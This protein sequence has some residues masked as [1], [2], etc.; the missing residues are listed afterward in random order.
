MN[1]AQRLDFWKTLCSLDGKNPENDCKLLSEKITFPRYLYRYRAVNDKNLE[2]LLH[3]HLF[4]SSANYFD[5]PFDTFL[6][7][8]IPKI[9]NEF[10]ANFANDACLAKLSE[11][12]TNMAS[13][14][15][16]QFPSDFLAAISDP[17]KLKAFHDNGLRDWFFNYALDL[18]TSI[19]KDTW[20]VC[21][22]ENGFNETLWLKYADCYH[23]FSLQYDLADEESFHCGKL[24]KC[25]QC[26][27]TKAA[28]SLYPMVYSDEPYDATSFAKYI[29]LQELSARVN[30]PLPQSLRD[31]IGSAVWERERTTLIKKTC[32]DPD[33]E[34]R[35][36]IGCNVKPPIM[37]EWVPS[38]VI[39]GLRTS[40]N[41]QKR[42]IDA[43]KEAGINHIY[44]SCIDLQ[45]K[46]NFFPIDR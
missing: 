7:I 19:R 21:F 15:G 13:L 38:G 17:Q 41:D 11:G 12:L 10:E 42:I 14:I 37:L 27:I 8:D 40:P 34:W 35:M 22:S 26:G 6:H 4:F 5:D 32:H 31:E 1:N 29:M 3:N 9:F 45:N 16:R 43:A 25:Q 39:L 33:Q 20:S 36:I 2:A 30:T 18:R 46:L 44:K 23:G 24:D 28:L